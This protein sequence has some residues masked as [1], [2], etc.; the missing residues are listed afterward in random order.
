[1]EKVESDAEAAALADINSDKVSSIEV[2]GSKVGGSKVGGS[3]ADV[4]GSQGRGADPDNDWEKV[5]FS[6]ENEI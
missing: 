4:E 3:V 2:G 1:M 6:P 5:E